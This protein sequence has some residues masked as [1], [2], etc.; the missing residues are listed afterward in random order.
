M[1]GLILC[2]FTLFI[3]VG[4]VLTCYIFYIFFQTCYKLGLEEQFFEVVGKLIYV[5]F[6]FN[7]SKKPLQ[8]KFPQTKR[9]IKRELKGFPDLKHRTK[10]KKN[11]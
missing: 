1:W 7:V 4:A 6:S 11:S 10:E 5:W 2:E 9:P 3:V 8:S